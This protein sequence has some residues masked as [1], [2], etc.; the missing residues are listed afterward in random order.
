MAIISVLLY[1]MY[2]GIVYCINI[3]ETMYVYC[4]AIIAMYRIFC[5]R[6]NLLNLLIS[7]YCIVYYM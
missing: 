4:V 6:Y 7:M 2:C 5:S 1:F 3:N